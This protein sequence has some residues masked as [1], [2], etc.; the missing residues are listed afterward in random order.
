M[1]SLCIPSNTYE[2]IRTLANSDDLSLHRRRNPPK[3][4]KN[5]QTNRS[6]RDSTTR[7]LATSPLCRARRRILSTAQRLPYPVV[8]S[9]KSRSSFSKC[10]NTLATLK[11][12]EKRGIMLD[13]RRTEGWLHFCLFSPNPGLWLAAAACLQ[14]T[15]SANQRRVAYFFCLSFFPVHKLTPDHIA[16]SIATSIDASYNCA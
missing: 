13:T 5:R 6:A 11:V 4:R 7:S 8:Q 3:P 16:M 2:P 12:R 14:D 1:S 9:N 10:T 15:I